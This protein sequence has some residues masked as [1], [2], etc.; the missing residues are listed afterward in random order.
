MNGQRRRFQHR[1]KGRWWRGGLAAAA[2]KGDSLGQRAASAHRATTVWHPVHVPDTSD[3]S[4]SHPHPRRPPQAEAGVYSLVPAS[5]LPLM[6]SPE[7]STWGSSSVPWGSALV[8]AELPCSAWSQAPRLRDVRERRA[9]GS[10]PGVSGPHAGE[11]QRRLG[12]CDPVQNAVLERATRTCISW[13]R[14]QGR[15]PQGRGVA[16]VRRKAQRLGGSQGQSAG[17]AGA[18]SSRSGGEWQSGD[19]GV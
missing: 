4:P 3:L 14:S 15:W 8:T 6:G 11:E 2:R 9:A 10:A 12:L 5:T 17:P 1:R 19:A 18:E 7:A 16:G 13:V